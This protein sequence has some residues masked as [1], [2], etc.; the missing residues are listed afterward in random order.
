MR[1]VETDIKHIFFCRARQAHLLHV[2]G[3]QRATRRHQARQQFAVHPVAF[4][5]RRHNLLRD[6]GFLRHLFVAVRL[7]PVAQPAL[8][9]LV[10]TLFELFGD[11]F[12]LV[13]RA[14]DLAQ[15]ARHTVHPAIIEVQHRVPGVCR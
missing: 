8:H 10:T 3:V 12:Q 4:F 7:I 6:A 11:A 5:H 15:V 13:L 14:R 9:Q 2:Q 1:I